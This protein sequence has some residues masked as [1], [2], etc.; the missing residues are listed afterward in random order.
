[1]QPGQPLVMFRTVAEVESARLA[2]FG[3]ET[4]G[5]RALDD[6]NYVE[7]RL[8]RA[9][10]DAVVDADLA[11]GWVSSTWIDAVATGLDE[12]QHDNGEVLRLDHSVE[13]DRVLAEEAV[14][15]VL[16]KPVTAP[17]EL[18]VPPANGNRVTLLARSE[19][20]GPRAYL[21]FDETRLVGSRWST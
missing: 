14:R 18:P 10:R 17:S 4:T 6:D 8:P 16:A 5:V 9:V 12:F 11:S 19:P 3:L 20:Q 7:V 2:A 21:T 15:E 1:M 13:A